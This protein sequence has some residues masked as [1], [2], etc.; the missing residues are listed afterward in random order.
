MTT[1][2]RFVACFCATLSVALA[3]AP[4][5]AASQPSETESRLA[6]VVP[7]VK[8]VKNSLNDAVEFLRDITGVNIILDAASLKTAGVSG[9]AP[10]SLHAQ[11]QTLKE[12]LDQLAKSISKGEQQLVAQTVG[13]KVLIASPSRLA[14]AKKQYA[15]DIKLAERGPAEL[16]KSMPEVNF[17]AVPLADVIEFMR[18]VTA[19][20]I[21]VN[22]RALE[23]AGVKKNVAV[24]VR[25]RNLPMHEAL[26]MILDSASEGAKQPLDFT[27]EEKDVIAVTTASAT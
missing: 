16:R 8:F 2:A 27:V 4:T 7:E 21:F 23:A 11:K 15:A 5:T 13:N 25:L 6:G 18:D 24:S 12:I 26:R 17:K 14:I 9:K 19:A 20:N 22:W 1:F 3:A 10:V